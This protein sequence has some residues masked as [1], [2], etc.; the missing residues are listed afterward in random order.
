[1]SIR[2]FYVLNASPWK[3]YTALPVNVITQPVL[4]YTKKYCAETFNLKRSE[5]VAVQ[6]K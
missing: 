2:Y 6:E 3:A 5:Y 4:M 1:M